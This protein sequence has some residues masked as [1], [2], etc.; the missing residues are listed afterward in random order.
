MKSGVVNNELH[1][2]EYRYRLEMR[3]IRKL[4]HVLKIVNLHGVVSSRSARNDANV[5]LGDSLDVYGVTVASNVY[6]Q[7]HHHS[8]AHQRRATR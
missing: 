6:C 8:S 3:K 5:C 1:C 4:G 2:L 7:I